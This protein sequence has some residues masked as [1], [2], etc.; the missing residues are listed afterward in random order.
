MQRLDMFKWSTVY[1]VCRKECF[2]QMSATMP[3]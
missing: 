3:F 1:S 2:G